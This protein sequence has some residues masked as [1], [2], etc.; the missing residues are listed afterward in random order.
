LLTIGG[1]KHTGWEFADGGALYFTL[2]EADLKAGRF[3]HV[4]MIMDCA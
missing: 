1:N 4:E 3:D 2:P